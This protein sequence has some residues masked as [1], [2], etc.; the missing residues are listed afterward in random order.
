MGMLGVSRLGLGGLLRLLRP[1]NLR[2]L[3]GL[4][5]ISLPLMDTTQVRSRH[6][7]K[8]ALSLGSLTR[9]GALLFLG[10]LLA[11]G[12]AGLLLDLLNLGS[13]EKG[14]PIRGLHI[15]RGNFLKV[16]I[17]VITNFAQKTGGIL[18]QSLAE[19][20][21]DERGGGEGGSGHGWQVDWLVGSS[22]VP[23]LSVGPT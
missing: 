10:L 7:G 17:V 2:L 14:H 15:L 11:L 19:D 18:T 23:T 6:R 9:T 4:H 20:A 22:K 1:F 12:F 5:P 16:Q 21:L 3:F 13:R 8:F